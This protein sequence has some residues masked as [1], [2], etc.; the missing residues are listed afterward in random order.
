MGRFLCKLTRREEVAAGTLAFHLERPPRLQFTPG[1]YVTVALID[2]PETDAQGPVRSFSMV[3]TPGND[4]LI[5]ATRL[6]D[7]AFKRVLRRLPLG[8]ELRVLG[9]VGTFTL[10]READRPAVFL[11]GGI[12]ITPFMSMIQQAARD[13]P[14]R[15]LTLFYANR[16]PEEAAFL[17]ALEEL[18]QSS[19]GFRCVPTM[20]DA[21]GSSGRWTGETGRI[22][23]AMLARHLPAL[24]G[25]LYY[26]AGPPAMVAAMRQMLASAG[27]PA[28]DVR[29]DEFSGY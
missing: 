8:T 16:R 3:S 6:R 25:P 2:P 1:Q 20:T 14:S 4:E 10:H 21:A 22:D 19:P 27:V 24:R 9:P 17:E 29:A 13:Q 28:G 15:P 26:A 7:S 12:G 11:A 18:A 23:A 5:F